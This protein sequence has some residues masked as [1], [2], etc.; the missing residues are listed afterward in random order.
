VAVVRDVQ[1]VQEILKKVLSDF[2][3]QEELRGK[4]GKLKIDGHAT[5]RIVN[6]VKK[7]FG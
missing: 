7:L 2:Q 5:D 4:M 6:L 1:K 3:Y